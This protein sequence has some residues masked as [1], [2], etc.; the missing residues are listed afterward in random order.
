MKIA[1]LNCGGDLELIAEDLNDGSDPQFR[2]W[3]CGN[4]GS[5]NCVFTP[6]D[7]AP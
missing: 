6:M 1:C 3:T 4:C 5:K 2:I 7:E